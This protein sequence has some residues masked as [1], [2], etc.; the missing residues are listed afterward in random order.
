[1][2]TR[3]SYETVAFDAVD[4]PFNTLVDPVPESKHQL[5][6]PLL[7]CLP[8]Q[9]RDGH[10]HA[11]PLPNQMGVFVKNRLHLPHAHALW[12]VLFVC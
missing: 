6:S 4:Q 9:G 12:N 3:R 11:V 1:M 5:G 7:S 10:H 2:I 8:S